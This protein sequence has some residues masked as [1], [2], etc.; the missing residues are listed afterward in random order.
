MPAFAFG[1]LPEET[2][3]HAQELRPRILQCK[4]M[5]HNWREAI[6]EETGTC[7]SQ[8]QR[9]RVT[10]HFRCVT[11]TTTVTVTVQRDGRR[12]RSY[13]YPEGY[14]RERGS[15][16]LTAEDNAAFWVVYLENI[17]GAKRRVR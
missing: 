3:I 2:L 15:G 12:T 1:K 7:E 16:H 6:Q 8:D 4:T 10:V 11:C 17:R 13:S 5:R 9:G 14:Q